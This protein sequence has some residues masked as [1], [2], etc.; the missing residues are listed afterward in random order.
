MENSNSTIIKRINYIDQLRAWNVLLMCYTHSLDAMLA[1]EYKGTLFFKIVNYIEGI[2][3]PS[4]L[5]VS[6]AAFA[7]VLHK[8]KESYLNYGKPAQKQLL[9]LLFLVLIAY[10]LNLPYKTFTQYQTL[11]TH[12]QF[13]MF[14]RSNNLHVIVFGILM[15]QILFLII[16]E[17]K[18]FHWIALG[19]A[20]VVVIVTPFIYQIDFAKT[21]PIYIATYFNIKYLSGFPLFHWLAYYFVGCFIM[22]QLITAIQ[23]NREEQLIKRLLFFSL[24]ASFIFIMLEVVGIQTSYYYDFWLSSPNI[25]IIRLSSVFLLVFF[26]WLIETKFNYRMRAFNVFK[27]ESLLVYV[28]HLMIVYGSV[29]GPG[30]ER[31]FGKTLSWVEIIGIGTTIAT[32]LLAVAYLW[33]WF[34]RE[35]KFYSRVLLFSIWIYFIY[36]F[37]TKPF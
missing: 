2:V 6:G 36:Y 21:F 12:D 25:F 17:E 31:L 19:L 23:E 18:K 15:S 34:K 26:F 8:R 37:F 20:G 28:L 29:L 16:R 13:I 1:D 30:I 22:Y 33:N 4:F 32:S 5:F 9:R 10:C 11:M 24:A 35:L 14:I 27:S 7:I 3:A